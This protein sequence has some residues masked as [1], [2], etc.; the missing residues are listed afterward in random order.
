MNQEHNNNDIIEK[1]SRGRPLGATAT[2]T[3]YKLEWKGQEYLCKNYTEIGQI[4]GKSKYSIGRLMRNEN[5]FKCKERCK[6]LL[7]IKITVL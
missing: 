6:D 7:D 1:R 3:K 5:T 4:V 2:K